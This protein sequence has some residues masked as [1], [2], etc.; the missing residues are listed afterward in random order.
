MKRL[1]IIFCSFGLLYPVCAQETPSGIRYA[2]MNTHALRYYPFERSADSIVSKIIEKKFN[3][4]AEKPY[5]QYDVYRKTAIDWVIHQ[6]FLTN[7]VQEG[8]QNNDFIYKH[9]VKPYLPWLKYARPQNE[10]EYHLAQTTSLYEDYFTCYFNRAG[11]EKGSLHLAS[12]K[13]G[14]YN[15]FGEENIRFIADGVMGSVDLFEKKNIILQRLLTGALSKDALS[16][17]RYFFSGQKTENGELLHE[18][19]F[20]TQNPQSNG[21][22]GFLYVTADERLLLR[23]AVFSTGFAISNNYISSVLFVQLFDTKENMTHPGKQESYFTFGDDI[24]GCFQVKHTAHYTHFEY[25][26]SLGKEVFKTRQ[27]NGGLSQ[28]EIFWEN[29][30][31][32]PLT[33]AEKQVKNIVGISTQTAAFKRTKNLIYLLLSDHWRIGGEKAPFEWGNVS[34]T[35]SHNQMEGMR[36]KAGGNTTTYL[37]R[38]F[39][40]GGY[41]AY[42]LKDKKF[43]YRGDIFYSFPPKENSIWEYPRSTLSFT[44]VSDLNVLG[45]D[46]LTSNRDNLFYSIPSVSSDDLIRQT[47]GLIAFER[48]IPRNFSF[49]LEG[50]YSREK[51][52]GS[53][54]YKPFTNSELSFSLQYAPQEL[55]VQVRNSR[56]YIQQGNIKINLKHRMGLK[57]VFGSEYN[58]H[59]TEGA[60]YKKIYLPQSAGHFNV[61]L[62]G[63]KV[64]N[65]LPYP[66][67]LI[68]YGKNGYIFDNENYNLMNPHEFVTDNYLA[69]KMNLFLNWS[70]VRLFT[71]KNGIR[72]SIGARMIYGALSANNDPAL[73]PELSPIDNNTINPLAKKPY[74]EVNAGL[75]N[76]F[77]IFRVEYVRRLTYP[78]HAKIRKGSLFVTVEL[79]F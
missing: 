60:I 56:T 14:L 69:G 23:K 35:I 26:E 70:P 42:G 1:L 39:Q 25:P 55:F 30:R 50:K 15:D 32:T 28:N 61:E 52:L 2:V 36:L 6:E 54:Q 40:L 59:V 31:P 10:N 21:F 34:Q 78:D 67:L 13:H 24:K 63:A 27:A 7:Q 51:P 20:Y 5:L 16:T 79:V 64:W 47:I 58:Y 44:Y 9:I 19:A 71:P 75:V 76:V 65:R 74:A 41:A 73:H 8:E 11:K 49:R 45:R 29:H 12:Q 68:L 37:N 18:I 3:A 62:S 72:T 4:D 43:K 77:Q 66:L 46:L 33:A 17:Y 57:G 53:L 22:E 38:H 48:E